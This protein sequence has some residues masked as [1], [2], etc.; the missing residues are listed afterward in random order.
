MDRFTY[1]GMSFGPDIGR[2][3]M[4]N[5]SGYPGTYPWLPSNCV[6]DV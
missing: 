5:S 6:W 2:F 1:N 3:S 4:S